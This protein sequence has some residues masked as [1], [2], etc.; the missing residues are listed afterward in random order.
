M[1]RWSRRARTV[2]ASTPGSTGLGRKALM[3]AAS[4][5]SAE[6][7]AHLAAIYAAQ[8]L[9]KQ[10]KAGELKVGV[11]SPPDI[12]VSFL[13]AREIG[14]RVPFDFLEHANFVYDYDGRPVRTPQAQFTVEAT[15]TH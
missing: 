9:D 11:V 12:A 5:V 8:I 13:K 3:P 1:A 10:A 15:A 4:A 2:R 7:N 6:S 14:M